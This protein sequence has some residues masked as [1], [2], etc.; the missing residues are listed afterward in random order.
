VRVVGLAELGQRVERD[1]VVDELGQVGQARRHRL[2]VP[3]GTARLHPADELLERF[4]VRG[5]GAEVGEHAPEAPGRRIV[6]GSRL[7]PAGHGEP[8]ARGARTN[9]L[10]STCGQLCGHRRSVGLRA[11]S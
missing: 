11:A 10:A 1:V 6:T 4:G 3:R 2:V 7:L 9:G 8:V 5:A